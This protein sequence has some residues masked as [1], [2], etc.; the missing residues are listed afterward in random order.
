VQISP[1]SSAIN[2]QVVLAVGLIVSPCRRL[3][4]A[5][6]AISTPLS[7]TPSPEE[8]TVGKCSA[9]SGLRSSAYPTNTI[10]SRK[11]AADCSLSNARA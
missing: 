2:A 3:A 8:N 7:A 9:C 10:L 1:A 5:V 11:A 6:A 4:K